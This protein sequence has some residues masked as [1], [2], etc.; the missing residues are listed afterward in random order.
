MIENT[1][2]MNLMDGKLTV[3]KTPMLDTKASHSINYIFQSLILPIP[4]EREECIGDWCR[5]NKRIKW[6]NLS[7]FSFYINFFSIPIF[8]SVYIG[9]IFSHVLFIYLLIYVVE[10]EVNLWEHLYYKSTSYF[11]M[12]KASSKVWYR[13]LKILTTRVWKVKCDVKVIQN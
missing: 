12:L 10:G 11:P 8:I 9:A 4:V 2:L 5:L 13:E 6:T 3:K 7:R 1:M